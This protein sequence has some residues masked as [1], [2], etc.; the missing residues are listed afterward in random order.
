MHPYLAPLVFCFIASRPY[1][2]NSIIQREIGMKIDIHVHCSELSNCGRNPAVE[3]IEAGI[4]AGL[5]GLVFTNHHKFVPDEQIAQYNSR[6]APFRVFNGIECTI[7][8]ED[9]LII[10]SQRAEYTSPKEWSYSAILRQVHDDG[11]CVVI[12]HPFRLHEEF[13]MDLHA[14]PPDA[15]EN[16]SVNVHAEN[17]AR[18]RQFAEE[19]GAP[20]TAASDAHRAEDVGCRYLEFD[21]D[22]DDEKALA[23]MI[24]QGRFECVIA[25]NIQRVAAK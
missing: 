22:I 6:Y 2:R 15:L 16:S 9:L 3:M 25:W 11:G 13:Q 8:K 20:V 4:E 14:E 7:E 17:Y 12:A 21:G 23:G 5:D 1:P 24:R 18:I 10:G 19:I